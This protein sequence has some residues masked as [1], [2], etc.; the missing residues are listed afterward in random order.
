[1]RSTISLLVV[2]A[3]LVAGCGSSD[4]RHATPTPTSTVA[5]IT[6]PTVAQSTATATRISAT[7]SPTS[8]A[9]PT[10]SDT[11]THT[12]TPTS[13]RST[14]TMAATSTPTQVSATATPTW[15]TSSLDAQDAVAVNESEFM[16]VEQFVQWAEALDRIGPENQRGLRATGSVEHERY[17][18]DLRDDLSRAGVQQLTLEAVPMDRW[19]TTQWS[20]DIIDGP[21]AG[22][23]RTASYIPYSGQ[24]GPEGVSGP[25]V[26]VEPGSTPEPGSLAGKIAVVDV[27]LTIIP[28]S[29]FAALSYENRVYDPDGEL[30]PAT[31]YKRPY[32]NGIIPVIDSLQAAGAAGVVAVLDYPSDGADGSYFPYDGII[33]GIP[34]VYVDRTTG[35]ALKDHAR[36][37]TQARLT[38]SATVEHVETRNLIG[39]IPGQS[40]ELVALHSHTDGTNG[41]EDNGPA[42]IVAISQ[43]LTRL[44]RQALPRTIMILLTTGH[45]AGGNGSRA[46]RAQHKDDLAAQTNAALT[47]EHLGA[48]EWDELPSGHMGPTGVYEPGG[49]FAPGSTALVDASYGALERADAAP[50]AVLK[51]LNPQADGVTTP[52]WPGEGQY[53]FARGGIPTSNYITGPTY[54][55]NW[56]I[57]TVD[58]IDFDRVRAEAIA[59]TEMILRLGRTSREELATFDLDNPTPTAQPRNPTPTAQPVDITQPTQPTSG[60]GGS[61]YPHANWRVSSGGSSNDAWYVFEPVDP[62]PASAPLAIV[63][64]GYFEFSGYNSMYEFI[65][66]TVRKGSVVIYPRWQTDTAIP[67]PGPFDIEPCMTSALNGIRGGLAFLQADPS[68]VQP[69]LD[70]TSYFGF[71]FGGIITANLANRYASLDLPEPRAIFFDDPHD[72]GLAGVGEPALDDSLAGI[73]STVKLQCHSGAD[74][75]ISEPNRA[76]SSCNAL[77]PLLGHIPDENKDLVLTETDRHGTPALSSAHGVCAAP[78][79]QAD[80]YDWNFCWKV[81]DAL[82]D[83]AYYGTNGKYALGDTPEHRSNGTWSDGVA[84]TPLKIQKE[85]PISP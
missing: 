70:K 45:F 40:E 17:I 19:T 10:Q 65:R 60:P 32:L 41:I 28:I 50:S 64:H 23:V 15:P 18:D 36:A 56:G 9:P 54:L 49:M 63:M 53:L 24:T 75:V 74:G 22:R 81:W 44:P 72:G 4:E 3:A 25:L 48:H 58:K 14:A 51:P 39:F 55:L 46:F 27:P 29:V 52:V 8:T 83:A 34:G 11:A 77:F 68:R 12:V 57:T 61:D 31:L 21:D 1:M 42:A 33:R 37:S 5:A 73:P 71:S 59:F 38:L 16:P 69:Q 67:C 7:P 20:L 76:N 84:I 79:D 62:Q 82:R 30:D 13:E 43:Y 35:A 85:A 78:P 2:T 6:T 26:F 80:A 47:I 66:H